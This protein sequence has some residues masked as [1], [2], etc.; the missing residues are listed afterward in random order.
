MK[1]KIL[2]LILAICFVVPSM[3]IFSACGEKEEVGLKNNYKITVIQTLNGIITPALYNETNSVTVDRGADYTFIIT[4]KEGYEID[5]LLIDGKLVKAQSIYTFKN[6][7]KDHSIG[8]IYT[9]VDAS[10]VNISS[11][12]LTFNHG[13]DY[14]KVSDFVGMQDPNSYNIENYP[15]NTKIELKG[16]IIQLLPKDNY[17]YNYLY[18]ETEI[19]EFS[20]DSPDRFFDVAG[21]DR[22][23]AVLANVKIGEVK[24]KVHFKGIKQEA[25]FNILIDLSFSTTRY[26]NEDC[27]GIYSKSFI[28]TASLDQTNT[29]KVTL[30]EEDGYE[31][32]FVKSVN[33]GNT[34]LQQIELVFND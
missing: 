19:A 6:V 8:A 28:M 27:Y 20:F 15:Q 3:F 34:F 13:S 14:L 1:K 32:I 24:N 22:D 2:S 23:R 7:D 17:D 5:N 11:I 33:N 25:R 30:I 10:T 21:N 31:D 9:L 12:R 29:N 16:R 18:E 26:K 4:P